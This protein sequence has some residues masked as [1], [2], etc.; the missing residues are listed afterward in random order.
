MSNIGNH[1]KTFN[2]TPISYAKKESYTEQVQK[3]VQYLHNFIPTITQEYDDLEKKS[4]K[5]PCKAFEDKM[6]GLAA[7]YS[8]EKDL[9]YWYVENCKRQV[10]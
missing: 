10:V 4:E 8:A 2:S 6:A 3:F 1:N 7:I 9:Y 5:K